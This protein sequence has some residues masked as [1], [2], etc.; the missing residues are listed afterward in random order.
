MRCSE[1]RI[2]HHHSIPEEGVPGSAIASTC[3]R[4]P[5]LV[6]KRRASMKFR[7]LYWPTPFEG[8]VG[9][10]TRIE[11]PSLELK[12]SVKMDKDEVAAL[13]DRGW[14]LVREDYPIHSQDPPSSPQP[15]EFRG[16]T[17]EHRMGGIGHRV[18]PKV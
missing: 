16:R 2:C 1:K 9:K 13:I 3:Q 11:S 7:P 8:D 17:Y 18:G 6:R 15:F 5:D 12:R 4:L 10:Y 14:K